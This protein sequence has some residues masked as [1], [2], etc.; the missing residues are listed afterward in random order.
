MNRLARIFASVFHGWEREILRPIITSLLTACALFLISLLSPTIREWLF[1]GDP[2]YPIDCFAEM[3][4]LPDNKINV[5]FYIINRAAEDRKDEFAREDLAILLADRFEGLATSPDIILRPKEGATIDEVK[6]DEVFFN[7]AEKGHLL[8]PDKNNPKEVKIVID[9]I[10]ARAILRVDIVTSN[11]YI[12]GGPIIR[13][14][15]G[16]IP[17]NTEEY[18]KR[19]YQR[20]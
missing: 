12:E 8:F 16:R 11:P 17:L 1:P 5:E 9:R 18:E 10:S 3:T 20:D 6:V 4:T 14:A 13:L 15:K 7:T 2:N 19:C